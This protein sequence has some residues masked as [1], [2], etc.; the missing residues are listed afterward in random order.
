MAGY[1]RTLLSRPLKGPQSLRPPRQLFA[2]PSAVDVH[3][4]EVEMDEPSI[5]EVAARPRTRSR[6]SQRSAATPGEKTL[7]APDR[8]MDAMPRS[9]RIAGDGAETASPGIAVKLL[10]PTEGPARPRAT[11]VPVPAVQERA[12]PEI[13]P[14]GH[15]PAAVQHV[16]SPPLGVR[17]AADERRSNPEFEVAAAPALPAMTA[18]AP[19]GERSAQIASVDRPPPRPA[20]ASQRFSRNDHVAETGRPQTAGNEESVSVEIG[21]VDVIIGEPAVPRPGPRPPLEPLS[22]GLAWA[23]GPPG[24]LG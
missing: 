10:E 23:E 4:P 2:P 21:R 13:E 11:D 18:S 9:M 20:P 12:V 7:E 6:D 24:R 19:G 5:P 3:S 17:F 15:R 14:G 1:F 16:E 22:K 8:D